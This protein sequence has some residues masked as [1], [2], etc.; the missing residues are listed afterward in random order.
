M[1]VPESEVI[2]GL[3]LSLRAGLENN[4][5][6]HQQGQKGAARK[7]LLPTKASDGLRRRERGDHRRNLRIANSERR[8]GAGRFQHDLVAAPPQIRE[9][10]QDER[11]GIAERRRLRPIIRDLRFDHDEVRTV[12]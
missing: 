10:R 5:A 6:I 4:L 7:T 12:S 9:P 1:K 11:A 3:G 8:A 2:L